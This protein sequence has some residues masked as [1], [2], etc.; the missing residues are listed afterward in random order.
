MSP[1]AAQEVEAA[2]KPDLFARPQALLS[3]NFAGV[4]P[5]DAALLAE[6]AG[7]KPIRSASFAGAASPRASPSAAQLVRA[8]GAVGANGGA[9]S[10][11]LEHFPLDHTALPTCGEACMEELLKEALAAQG[12]SYAPG[13]GPLSGTVTLGVGDASVALDIKGLAERL[14]AV[15]LA[16]LHRSAADAAA[17]ERRRN[18]QE[19]GRVPTPAL[20]QAT[21]VSPQ[22]LRA[23][24]GAADPRADA[25]VAMLAKAAAAAHA[26]VSEA[27]GG[28]A[29][30]HA[31]LLGDVP[32]TGTG[33]KPLLQWQDA[34]RR[35]LQGTGTGASTPE[36]QAASVN[37]ATS[38]AAWATAIILVFFAL[39]SCYTLANM[40]F[41]LDSL[42]YSRQKAE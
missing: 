38:S 8:V 33:L 7:G 20:L 27:S 18:A 32:V 10:A 36:E 4:D 21:L 23:S 41:K 13:A 14:W 34:H 28:R 37:W 22:A 39:V 29:A 42:L 5:D 12:A 16:A 24:L 3:I 31:A 2:L 9:E 15:E 26:A 6:L 30:M 17:E 35:R 11:A 40:R 25:A 19:P 1:A